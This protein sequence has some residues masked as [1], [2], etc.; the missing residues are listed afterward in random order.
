MHFETEEAIMHRLGYPHI[1]SHVQEHRS[2]TQ[3]YL[4]LADDIAHQRH[5]RL[6]LGFQIQLFLFDW[7][8]NHTTR[9]DRYLT[10]FIASQADGTAT[11]A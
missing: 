3:R 11:T 7:F 2:F 6:Y 5:S 1:A 4:R 9:T 8:A 10:R